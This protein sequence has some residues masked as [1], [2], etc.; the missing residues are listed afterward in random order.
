MYRH[1]VKVRV[2]GTL[3]N[4]VRSRVYLCVYIT[5]TTPDTTGA[6]C[7]PRVALSRSLSA[8]HA[9][10]R[11]S[12]TSRY[13]TSSPP[14]GSETLPGPRHP[15]G[16]GGRD[17]TGRVPPPTVVIALRTRGIHRRAVYTGMCKTGPPRRGCDERALCVCV[18]GVRVLQLSVPGVEGRGAKK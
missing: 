3:S 8:A 7:T 11:L 18:C 16:R 15:I 14:P 5:C 9:H 12:R 1:G 2:V 10:T 13:D 4:N 17:N 6:R